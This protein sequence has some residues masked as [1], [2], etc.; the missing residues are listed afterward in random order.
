MENRKLEIAVGLFLLIGMACLAYLSLKLGEVR[1]WG[2]SDY[3]VYATFS[4][5]GGLKNKATVTM[6]G[7]TIG[8]VENIRLKD[9]QA[10]VTL[11]IHKDVKLEEDVIASIKTMGIIG[12]KYLAVSPGAAEQYIKNGGKIMDTQPPL[13]IEEMI[14]KFVFGKV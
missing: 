13:D 3:I 14:G 6:A 10:L 11:T 7:V 8:Q 9:G 4:N 5:V 12:D 1:L 2:S